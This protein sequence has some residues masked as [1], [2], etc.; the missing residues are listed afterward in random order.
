[1]LSPNRVTVEISA[2]RRTWRN[3]TM[4][5]ASPLARAKS[6]YSASS[7]SITAARRLRIRIAAEAEGQGQGRQEQAVEPLAP[8]RAVTADGEPAQLGGEHGEQQEAQI[9]HRCGKADLEDATDHQIGRAVAPQRSQKRQRHGECQRDQA[10][11]ER[12]HQCRGQTLGDQ[13]QH[14]SLQGDRGAEITVREAKQEEPE[15]HDDRPVEAELG[16]DPRHVGVVGPFAQE[17]GCRITGQQAHQDEGDDGDQEQGRDEL[18]QPRQDPTWPGQ[19]YG[20]RW[21]PTKMLLPSGIWMK[22]LTFCCR[23]TG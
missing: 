9:E 7:T 17:R 12:Q 21:A 13:R 1:M 16:V 3:S 6:T 18:R 10:R 15:L 14:G 2:L 22:P 4:R 19:R 20:S 23:A 11:V 8:G 5:G